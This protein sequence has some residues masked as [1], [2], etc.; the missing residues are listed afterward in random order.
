MAEDMIWRKIKQEMSVGN[1][2]EEEEKTS[3]LK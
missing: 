3:F 1:A 2:W